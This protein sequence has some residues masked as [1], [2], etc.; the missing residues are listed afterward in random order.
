MVSGQVYMTYVQASQGG[1]G[2]W[3]M[4]VFLTPELKPIVGGTYFHPDDKY[5]RPGFKTVLKYV[6]HIQSRC[7][8][9]HWIITVCQIKKVLL[10]HKIAVE[11][12][13]IIHNLLSDN[14][15]NLQ[16]MT[17]YMTRITGIHLYCFGLKWIWNVGRRVREVWESKKDLL[18]E[19]GNQV[20]QQL[21]EATAAMA[22][23]TKLTE[24]SIVTQAVS[25][26]ALQVFSS[27]DNHEYC[28]YFD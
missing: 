27:F 18:R 24:T 21:A 15:N 20:V 3:P 22:P 13:K 4:S 14:C 16:F 9:Q 17:S 25:L 8:V 1:A 19:T 23:S 28:V 26:C 7:L 12:W 10:L 5:G 11:K 2:G 6:Y